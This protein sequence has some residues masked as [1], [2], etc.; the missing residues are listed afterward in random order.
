MADGQPRPGRPRRRLGRLPTAIIVTLVLA[1]CQAG[2]Q[3][4]PTPNLYVDTDPNPF[5]KVPAQF[6][7]N[8]V[9]LL[10]ATDRKPVERKDGKLAYGYR[11]GA[12][13][14][15]RSGH[16]WSRSATA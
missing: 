13:R 2:P 6:R 14:R 7:A 16:A 11:R 4:M 10:Y 15:W 8:T 9:D 3:L 5:A 12:A 1:G